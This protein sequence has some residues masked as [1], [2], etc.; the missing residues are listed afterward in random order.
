M[1]SASDTFVEYLSTETSPLDVFWWRKGDV[2]T[3]SGFLKQDALNV[4]ILGF[5][6]DGSEEMCLVSLDLLAA[7]DR[8]ALTSLKTV[9]D[10]LIGTQFV[11]E[12]D[13]SNPDAPRF[14][15]RNIS[16][17]AR[18]IKFISVRTPAGARYAHYNATFPLSYTRE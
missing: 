9:R 17:D 14:T 4:S 12:R 3:H 6:E 8:A 15:G 5:W 16:W 18:R 10:A 2:D 1:L 11:P 7:D 13:F